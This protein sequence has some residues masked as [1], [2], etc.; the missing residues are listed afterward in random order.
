MIT[1]DMFTPLIDA[2]KEFVPVALTVGVSI[3]AITWGARK[4]FNFVKSM[5]K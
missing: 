3:F 2:A 1:A 4:G 5:T